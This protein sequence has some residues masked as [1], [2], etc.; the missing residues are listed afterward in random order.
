MMDIKASG[1]TK[2]TLVAVPKAVFNSWQQ[3]AAFFYPKLTV[4]LWHEKAKR[5]SA[6]EI[7]KLAKNGPLLVLTNEAHLKG[8]ATHG[9]LLD[10]EWRRV[11]LDESQRINNQKND[12]RAALS[13]RADFKWSLSGTPIENKLGDFEAHLALI[14]ATSTFDPPMMTKA[15]NLNGVLMRRTKLG[16]KH[17]YPVGAGGRELPRCFLWVGKSGNRNKTHE[18]DAD[19]KDALNAYLEKAPNALVRYIKGAI[20]SSV[21]SYDQPDG[22]SQMTAT[23]KKKLNDALIGSAAGDDKDEGEDDNDSE[24]EDAPDYETDYSEV[25]IE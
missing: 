2:P 21:R 9:L 8:H 13:L 16:V 15:D 3:D 6:E 4:Y 7:E 23:E 19:E 17:N 5:I 22:P 18:M 14:G 11:V 10:V 24:D 25:E 20:R 12:F 1:T